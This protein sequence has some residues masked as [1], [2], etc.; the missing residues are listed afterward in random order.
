MVLRWGFKGIPPA[1]MNS[2]VSGTHMGRLLCAKKMI[3]K[4]M[5][6]WRNDFVVDF[7]GNPSCSNEF[8]GPWDPYGQATL[9]KTLLIKLCCRDFH[10]F[11]AKL[12]VAPGT[13]LYIPYSPVKG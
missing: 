9:P 5:I 1:Q 6:L 10:F 7:Q 2:M 11:A 12:Q 8:Y 3:L 13:S 4:K